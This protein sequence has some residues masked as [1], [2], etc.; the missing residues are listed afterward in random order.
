M[1]TVYNTDDNGNSSD[2]GT[3]NTGEAMTTVTVT[4]MIPL[5]RSTLLIHKNTGTGAPPNDFPFCTKIHSPVNSGLWTLFYIFSKLILRYYPVLNNHT[6][7][8]RNSCIISESCKNDRCFLACCKKHI[9]H[10]ISEYSQ[11]MAV[12]LWKHHRR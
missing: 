5:I 9:S 3:D 12:R 2:D 1:V 8:I 10:S 11:S 4:R 7:Q 6:A